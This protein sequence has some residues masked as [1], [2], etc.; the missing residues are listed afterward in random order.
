MLYNF[1]LQHFERA[2]S[3]QIDGAV[4]VAGSTNFF[5]YL[6]RKS[7]RIEELPEAIVVI[8]L[9]GDVDLADYWLGGSS[10]TLLV[11]AEGK[12]FKVHTGIGNRLY[13]IAANE[14]HFV[15][16][17]T[18]GAIRFEDRSLVENEYKL[19]TRPSP[20]PI[21]MRLGI[22]LGLPQNEQE[23]YEALPHLDRL[24]FGTMA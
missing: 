12:W 23:E 19:D 18:Y 4:P 20:Q 21:L 9:H 6:D 7:I 10:G 14:K 1:P 3:S 16:G 17:G 5:A 11:T 13:G 15:I 8:S 24:L 2:S 22:K